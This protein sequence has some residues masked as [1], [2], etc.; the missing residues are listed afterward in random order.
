M[1]DREVSLNLPLSKEL[2]REIELEIADHIGCASN[3]ASSNVNSIRHHLT[4]PAV[5]RKLSAPHLADQVAS[6]L[7]RLPDKQE[8]R[9]LMWLLIWFL[10]VLL[11]DFIAGTRETPSYINYRNMRNAFNDEFVNQTAI[12][13]LLS[14]IARAGFFVQFIATIA[15]AYKIGTGVM[16]ARLIQL[17]LVHT[18]LVLLGYYLLPLEHY[19]AW[20]GWHTEWQHGWLLNGV[21]LT[22]FLVPA[23][24]LLLIVFKRKLWTA[25]VFLLLLWVFLYQGAPQK[26]GE[27]K[28]VFQSTKDAR[29]HEAVLVET[30]PLPGTAIG[31]NYSPA[32]YA[33]QKEFVSLTELDSWWTMPGIY[34][35]AGVGWLAAPIP[36]LAIFSLFA[37]W[38]ILGRR[39]TADWLLYGALTCLALFASLGPFITPSYGW[40]LLKTYNMIFISPPIV[41]FHDFFYLGVQ[42]GIRLL[43]FAFV[44][45]AFVPWLMVGL[46]ARSNRREAIATM[47][48]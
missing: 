38:F 33:H 39:S 10:L 14:G 25:S 18:L 41:T 4:S 37:M 12:A 7:W 26:A 2:R 27:Y 23:A 40:V 34:A 17:K 22:L 13:W 36:F 15:V 3:A 43:A 31:K 19:Y 21:I 1:N 48:E 42:S 16:I 46:F 28:F 29:I 8:L 11:A 47:Q 5:L 9:Y 30:M 32:W 6:T 45:S 44:I 35:G 24:I 20:R